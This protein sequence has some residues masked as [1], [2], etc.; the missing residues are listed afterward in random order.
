M[1]VM[2]ALEPLIAPAAAAR[3]WIAAAEDGDCD[4]RPLARE[5]ARAAVDVAILWDMVY[6]VMSGWWYAICS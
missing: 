3:W 2:D 4:A 1:F 6:S 5:A